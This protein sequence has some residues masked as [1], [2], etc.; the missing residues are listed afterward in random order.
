MK[1]FRRLFSGND[2]KTSNAMPY[3]LEP[4]S[5]V[6][7]LAITREWSALARFDPDVDFNDIKLRKAMT[8]VVSCPY[9][10][11]EFTF[12]DAVSIRGVDFHVQCPYCNAS[13]SD[14][15]Y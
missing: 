6:D 8:T 13:P 14:F 9:C 11:N 10:S 5:F 3:N 15:E 2:S 4:T 7:C 12:G 1:M